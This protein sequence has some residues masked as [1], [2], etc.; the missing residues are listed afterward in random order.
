MTMELKL[1]SNDS[2]KQGIHL[3]S[4]AVFLFWEVLFDKTK[5][6]QLVL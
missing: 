3:F 2:K 1:W 5:S 6:Q 4:V